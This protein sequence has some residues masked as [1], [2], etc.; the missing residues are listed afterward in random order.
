MANVHALKPKWSR[1]IIDTDKDMQG[2]SLTNLTDV[3]FKRLVTETDYI[4]RKSPDIN[5]FRLATP[6]GWLEI[7]P[8]NMSFCH[9]YTS[10]Q[11]FFFGDNVY[12]NGSVFP[13]HDK[14][15]NNGTKEFR[16]LDGWFAGDLGLG[17]IKNIGDTLTV[18]V[19][20]E[21]SYTEVASK[22][23][24]LTYTL[25]LGDEVVDYVI[26]NLDTYTKN[27]I[28][29]GVKLQF[30]GKSEHAYRVYYKLYEN[31]VEVLSIEINSTDYNTFSAEYNCLKS[32]AFY[33]CKI[34]NDYADGE[35][36]SIKNRY[37][38]FK[39]RYIGIKAGS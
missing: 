30:D 11:P 23:D 5:N 24:E 3:E 1:V 29:T 26:G 28:I 35:T 32:S 27:G 39:K 21:D 34:Y 36:V 4:I 22:P 9:F 7:G 20:Y 12:I 16:W 25:D 31:S 38:Y 2:K 15:Y 37:L 19:I 10:E 18:G 17:V 6:Y 14:E 33:E 13:F 8:A